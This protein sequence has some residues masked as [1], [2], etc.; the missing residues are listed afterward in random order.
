MTDFDISLHDVVCSVLGVYQM[1]QTKHIKSGC[2][3]LEIKFAAPNKSNV[4]TALLPV[5]TLSC[6]ELF[7]VTVALDACIQLFNLISP[8]HLKVVDCNITVDP[9]M[10]SVFQ[11]DANKQQ[12]S[13]EE[14]ITLNPFKPEFTIVIFIH[15]KPRIAV[16]I[17]DL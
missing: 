3:Q 5:I 12:V 11:S 15:Y 2:G 4:N 10:P 9:D 16:A 13:T 6:I 8:S 17:L 7:K 14:T 1:L